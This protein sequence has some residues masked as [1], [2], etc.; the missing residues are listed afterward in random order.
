MSLITVHRVSVPLTWLE[1]AWPSRGVDSPR[2]RPCF[3]PPEGQAVLELGFSGTQAPSRTSAAPLCP[4]SPAR[5]LM[6]L[7]PT[8][9]WFILSSHISALTL[10]PQQADL[11][12]CLDCHHNCDPGHPPPSIHPT[13]ALL[14]SET[15]SPKMMYLLTPPVPLPCNAFPFPADK[16]AAGPEGGRLP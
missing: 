15:L 5:P 12:S 4:A 2:L 16:G 3:L 6:P 8:F 13:L 14:P 11:V 9:P 7:A 1:R 10:P